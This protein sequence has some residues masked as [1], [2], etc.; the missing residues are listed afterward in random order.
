MLVFL[1]PAS[2][3]SLNLLRAFL[4]AVVFCVAPNLSAE[5]LTFGLSGVLHKESNHK[6][7]QPLLMD[8]SDVLGEPVNILPFDDYSSGIWNLQKNRIQFAWMGNKIAIEA[9][10]RADAEVFAQV[11][12]FDGSAGYYSVLISLKDKPYNSV[13]EVLSAAGEI[14]FGFGDRH[15]TSGTVV[16]MFY[17]FSLN[18]FDYRKMHRIRHANHEENFKSIVSGEIDVATISSVGLKRFEDWYPEEYKKI[19]VIW[20]SPLIPSDTLVWR[21]DLDPAVK[22]KVKTFFLSYG[23][24]A[25]NK[26]AEKVAMEQQN[27]ANMKWSG[28]RDSNNDQLLPVRQIKLFTEIEK[29]HNDTTLSEQDRQQKIDMLQLQLD[30]LVP[31]P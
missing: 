2:G 12:T 29:V 4:L 21:T 17:L 19:K 24:P 16:P 8:L 3:S 6:I 30:Q 25:F 11:L 14:T 31:S 23:R 26:P 22:R 5:P 10:D 27:L 7:W 9:V 20:K 15:S 28:F 13:E 1:R 18:N